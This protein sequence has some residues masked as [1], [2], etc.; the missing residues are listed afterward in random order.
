[1]SQPSKPVNGS[2]AP[3]G[4]VEVVLGVVV[5]DV[6]PADATAVP[7][8]AAEPDDDAPDADEDPE[9]DEPDDELPE[10]EPEP[11]LEWGEPEDE[12]LP[13][14]PSGSTYC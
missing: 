4:L 12:P 6:E 2:V 13:E 1:L 9:D 7:D 5:V 10:L 3:A 11:E 14:P 8:A